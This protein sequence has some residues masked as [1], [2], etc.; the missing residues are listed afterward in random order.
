MNTTFKDYSWH[1]GRL[2][3]S[4]LL[5]FVVLSSL[6]W[7]LSNFQPI[8]PLDYLPV[9]L[10]VSFLTAMCVLQRNELKPDGS[11]V[12]RSMTGFSKEILLV[13][14][15]VSIDWRQNSWCSS[16]ALF[17][18]LTKSGNRYLG[19]S[20]NIDKL[21]E[22]LREQNPHIKDWRTGKNERSRK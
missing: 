16:Q 17:I 13:S 1:R 20:G 19:K 14:E 8:H 12:I 18:V 22:K 15:I 21:L 4:A 7:I 11:L 10:I 2:I 9:F 5:L 6:Q 3:L